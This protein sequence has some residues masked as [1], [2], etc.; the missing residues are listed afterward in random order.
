VKP[1]TLHRIRSAAHEELARSPRPRPWWQDAVVLAGIN[2]A[3]AIVCALYLGSPRFLGNL[4]QPPVLVAVAVPVALMIVL[5]AVAAVMPG[6]RAGLASALV[7]VVIGAAAV[8]SGGTGSADGGGFL[9]SG[10]PCMRSEWVMATVPTAAAIAVL[11][12]FAYS[13]LRMLVGALSG[14]ATGLLALHLHCPI[15]TASHLLVFHI[16]PWLAAAGIAVFI[17]SRVR[18]RSFAP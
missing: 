6:G 8:V 1:E 9:A 4:A 3:V 15:G 18:S 16:L 11:S 17:R 5:G 2:S 12:R 14:G 13:P 10:I 7:L